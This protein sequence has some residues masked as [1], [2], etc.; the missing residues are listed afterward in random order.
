MA[1]TGLHVSAGTG[2]HGLVIDDTR[3]MAG[4]RSLRSAAGTDH[5]A[6]QHRRTRRHAIGCPMTAT[7]CPVEKAGRTTMINTNCNESTG[8]SRML[9]DDELNAVVGGDAK[10]APPPTKQASGTVFEVDDFSFDI[11]QVL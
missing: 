4:H 2:L 10:A 6:V 9:S 5:R 7:W 1:A 8:S 3:M 11:E